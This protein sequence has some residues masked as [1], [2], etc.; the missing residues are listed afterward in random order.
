MSE[1][2]VVADM[3]VRRPVQELTPAH[4]SARRLEPQG[5]C[6]VQG[7]EEGDLRGRRGRQYSAVRIYRSVVCEQQTQHRG[8]SSSALGSVSR[9][10]V[11]VKHDFVKKT[12]Y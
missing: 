8:F 1:R 5:G 10:R 11:Q 12:F 4:C 6:R 2:N 9:S 7:G 3:L